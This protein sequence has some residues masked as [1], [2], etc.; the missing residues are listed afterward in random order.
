[1]FDRS[2]EINELTQMQVRRLLL[3]ADENNPSDGAIYQVVTRNSEPDDPRIL[4]SKLACP[5]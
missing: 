4:Q 3:G 5:S 2:L 1:M